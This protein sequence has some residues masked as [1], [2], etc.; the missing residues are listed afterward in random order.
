MAGTGQSYFKDK[1]LAGAKSKEYTLVSSFKLGYRNREDITNLPPGVLVKG[2]QNVLTNVSERIGVRKG[3]TLYGQSSTVAG[4]VLGVYDW[5]PSN[6]SDRGE[7]HV[8]SGGLTTAGNDGVLQ[9]WYKDSAGVVSWRDLMTGLINTNLNFTEYWDTT[10]LSTLLLFVM[11]DTNLYEWSGAYGTIATTSNAAGVISVLNSVPTAGGTGYTVGDI[12]TITTGGTGATARVLT[13][14]GSGAVATVAL[15]TPGTGYTT[16]GSKAT[17]GG[18]GT[19]AT[20]DI[21]TVVTGFI[22]LNGTQTPSELGFYETSGNSAKFKLV[23]G[24]IT[25]TYTA[26]VGNY[27]VGISPDPTAITANAIIHQAV[28]INPNSSLTAF[29]A[30]FTNNLISSLDNQVYIG[31]FTNNSVYISKTNDYKNYSFT[32][33]TRLPHEGAVVI[34]DSAPVG[35]IPQ[36]TTMYMTAGLSLWYTTQLILGSDQTTETFQVQRLKT[37]AQE[38]AQSQALIGKIKNK[39]V[40]ISN[41]PTMDELGLIE[42]INNYPQ[43]VNISD[44]IKLDFDVYDFTD[45]SVFYFQYFIYIAIPRSGVTRIYNMVTKNWEAPQTFPFA[46]FSI[47]EGEL[48]AHDY[49]VLQSYKLFDGYND[50]GHPILAQAVFSY[51]NGG[52]PPGL[53]SMNAYYV[54]GYINPNTTLNLRITYETDGNATITNYYLNGSD[55]QFVA[56]LMDDSSLGKTSLGKNSLGGRFTNQNPAG[57][58][59]KFRWVPTFPRKDHFEY[60]PSFISSGIDNRW[61]ILRFGGNIGQAASEPVQIKA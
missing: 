4:G 12:L 59:P 49:S 41:E 29:P 15:V 31:S 25:Y 54:E 20:L 44:P 3:Y 8:R 11:G 24:G 37:T 38:A 21:T 10:E 7:R 57:L 55:T 50:N 23:A 30:N 28:Y 17:T 19:S 58:P 48:Y 51:E 45:G 26:I 36:Q 9:Y 60:Q 2:S 5:L 46:R 13:L 56:R 32:T 16:G 1:R 40:F 22:T 61:E 47:I 34:L 14:G 27:F 33:P 53:K 6:L 39:V 42:G 52:N 43:T 18:S 35:L